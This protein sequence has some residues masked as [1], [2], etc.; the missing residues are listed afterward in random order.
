[1]LASQMLL[2]QMTAAFP[3]PV[4]CMHRSVSVLFLMA[5][6]KR[7]VSFP[8]GKNFKGCFLA[9]SSIAMMPVLRPL[10]VKMGNW[11]FG[12]ALVLMLSLCLETFFNHRCPEPPINILVVLCHQQR[13]GDGLTRSWSDYL[14][15]LHYCV[16]TEKKNVILK[17]CFHVCSQA[18]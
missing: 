3:S 2:V 7:Q 11:D 8:K 14:G 10:L 13:C 9:H 17:S 6:V 15:F 5:P 4:T 18:T 1:M 16:S 12:Q